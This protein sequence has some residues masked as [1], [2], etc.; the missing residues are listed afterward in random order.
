MEG[1][2]GIGTS[3]ISESGLSGA[4]TSTAYWASVTGTAFAVDEIG[5]DIIGESQAAMDIVKPLLVVIRLGPSG[6][7]MAVDPA[8]VALDGRSLGCTDKVE[9][10]VLG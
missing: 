5:R 7:T 8:G 10:A 6:Y 1:V 2:D 3:S 9:V 4:T